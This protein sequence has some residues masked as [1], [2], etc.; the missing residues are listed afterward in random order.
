MWASNP[1][2]WFSELL[3]CGLW[4]WVAFK[5]WFLLC[6]TFHKCVHNQRNYHT[7][8]VITTSSPFANSTGNELLLAFLFH[9]HR[10]CGSQGKPRES[11]RGHSE[12]GASNERGLASTR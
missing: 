9:Q 1:T 6:L 11:A 3:C 5:I 12:P 4:L 2:R 7:L 10:V 8:K